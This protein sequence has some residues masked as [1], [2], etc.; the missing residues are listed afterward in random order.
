MQLE[1]FPRA[2]PP[3]A[4]SN[5]QR[6]RRINSTYDKCHSAR[7]PYHARP[8]ECCPAQKILI[9]DSEA[10]DGSADLGNPREN[11]GIGKEGRT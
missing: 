2:M 1:V 11:H 4:G 8:H 3:T 6:L 5:G 9:D 7:R 10:K